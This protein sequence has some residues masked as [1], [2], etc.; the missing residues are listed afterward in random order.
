[1]ERI[2]DLVEDRG[3]EDPHRLIALGVSEP[4]TEILT[5]S[6]FGLDERRAELERVIR[7]TDERA[8]DHR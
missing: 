4:L 1:M 7:E 8:D 5:A 6:T 2:F 3:R